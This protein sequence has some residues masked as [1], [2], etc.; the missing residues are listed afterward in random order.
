MVAVLVEYIRSLNQF[1]IEVEVIKLML[2][3]VKDLFITLHVHF[4]CMS[5]CRSPLLAARR[6]NYE[7]RSST[8]LAERI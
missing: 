3:H 8:G 4:V 7:G 5:V 6:L 2:S 1:L